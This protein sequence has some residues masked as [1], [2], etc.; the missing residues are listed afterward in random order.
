MKP[1]DV[2]APGQFDYNYP[3]GERTPTQARYTCMD[4]HNGGINSLFLDGSAR[5][6]GLK[7]L[8]T[9]KWSRDFS[10]AGSWTQAGGVKAE[11]WPAWMRR[12]KDY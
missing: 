11:D 4:R 10:I 5:K 1:P 8:W 7:E 12:F 6:V 2:D 3:P 9:L